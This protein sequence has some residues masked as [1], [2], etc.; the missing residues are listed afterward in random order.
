[1]FLVTIIGLSLMYFH[2]KKV[3]WKATKMDETVTKSLLRS[4]ERIK[5]VKNIKQFWQKPIAAQKKNEGKAF[6]SVLSLLCFQRSFGSDFEMSFD[7]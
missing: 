2:R 7:G 3:I 5:A 1:M 6:T 4:V